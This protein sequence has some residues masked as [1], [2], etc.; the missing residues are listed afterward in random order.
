M[1]YLHTFVTRT[2]VEHKELNVR[3][4][5]SLRYKGAV[6]VNTTPSTSKQIAARFEE[7]ENV[8]VI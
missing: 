7:I 1:H 5:R 4:G 2:I 3:R 6:H 8:D